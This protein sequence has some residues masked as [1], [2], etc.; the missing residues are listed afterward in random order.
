MPQVETHDVLILGSGEAGKYLAWTLAQQGRRTAMIERRY[1]GGSCPNIACLP[2]K[3]VIHS[4]EVA[5]FARR[6]TEF[7][8]ELH[9]WKID[10]AAVRDRKRKTVDGEIA[11]HRA[12]RELSVRS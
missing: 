8:V 12:F 3:N 2:S 9:D 6:A 7:G 5:N 1:M 11:F 4:A 10:M